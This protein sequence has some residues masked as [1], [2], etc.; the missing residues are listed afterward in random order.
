MYPPETHPLHQQQVMKRDP[1]ALRVACGL[2][3]A[4]LGMLLFTPQG[5]VADVLLGGAL[6]FAVV[7]VV[8]LLATLRS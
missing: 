8:A 6:G 5:W 4:L 2:G 7:F 1:W 3:G